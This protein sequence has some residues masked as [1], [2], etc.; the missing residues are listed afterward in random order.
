MEI[1]S[2]RSSLDLLWGSGPSALEALVGNKTD[3]QD[4]NGTENTEHENDTGVFR[5]EVLSRDENVN[6]LWDDESRH[7]EC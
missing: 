3:D 1:R 4:T 5:G 6:A 2:A 7:C